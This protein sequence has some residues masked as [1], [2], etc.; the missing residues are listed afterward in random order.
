MGRK[1][2]ALCLRMLNSQM[3]TKLMTRAE[4]T[5]TERQRSKE[6]PSSSV[7]LSVARAKKFE[8]PGPGDGHQ[9]VDARQHRAAAAHVPRAREREGKDPREG[10]LRGGGPID[11]LPRRGIAGESPVILALD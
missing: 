3:S 8:R 6:S 5:R 1:R 2:G 7:S 10:G 9:A 11:G 4:A